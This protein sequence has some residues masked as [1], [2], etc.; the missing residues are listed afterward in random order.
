MKLKDLVI[1]AF[2]L[3]IYIFFVKPEIYTTNVYVD[4]VNGLKLQLQKEKLL[5]DNRNKVLEVLKKIK[6]ANK[7]NE[8]LFFPAD[9]P[10][11]SAMNQLQEIIKKNVI[12]SNMELV[13]I[14][15][16]QP[17]KDEKKF[18]YAL[19]MNFIIR[20]NPAALGSFFKKIG[21]S[22]KLINFKRFTISNYN[23]KGLL[24]N[25]YVLGYK[26]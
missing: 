15:W 13:K 22:A 26:L 23:A 25:A 16:G 4:K 14:T 1:I 2:L 21:D 24:I 17:F 3:F 18:Y 12:S 6:N 5:R 9:I 7:K 11:A 8:D 19:P 20:G 10:A